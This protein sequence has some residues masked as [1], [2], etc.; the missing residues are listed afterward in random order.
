[1]STS[2]EDGTECADGRLY[3]VGRRDRMIKTLGYRVSP[4]E[5]TDVLFASGLVADAAITTEPDPQRGDRIVAH[6]VLRDG[7]TLEAIRRWS[8]VELPRH[9]RR[10]DGH[11]MSTYPAMRAASTTSCGWRPRS[12]PMCPEPTWPEPLVHPAVSHRADA[13]DRCAARRRAPC[14]ARTPTRIQ[15]AAR[16]SRRVRRPTRRGRV[17]HAPRTRSMRTAARRAPR[18]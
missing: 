11:F 10:C 3:Y 6:L 16:R 12:G 14:S 13:V 4:D 18:P 7:T 15:A 9:M 1:M 8:G 17:S 5:I 2:S